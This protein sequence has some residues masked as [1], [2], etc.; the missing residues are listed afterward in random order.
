VLLVLGIGLA[1]WAGIAN[2]RQRQD[3]YVV[4]TMVGMVTGFLL[5][6]WCL[7]FSR[8]RWKVRLWICGAV[9]ALV[10]L[11]PVCFRL[12]GVSGDLV[13]IPEWRWKHPAPTPRVAASPSPAPAALEDETALG[14]YP[15]FLGPARNATVPGPRLARDW[16]AQPP[17]EIWQHPVG[18]GWSGFAV[19][20]HRAITQEQQGAEETVTC[21]DVRSGVLLWRHGYPAHFQSDLAGEGPR[22]TPT[23]A[24]NRVWTLGSTGILTCLRLDDGSL[25][26]SKDTLRENESKVNEWGDSCSPLVLGD[27]VVVS[28][29]GNRSRSLVAYDAATGNFVWGAGDAGAGYSSPLETTLGGV[30]QIL[31]FNAQGVFGH[32]AADGKI[33]WSY[34]WPRGHPHVAMPVVLPGDRVLASSGY[35]TGSEVFHVVRDQTGQFATE[36]VWKSTRL[37]AKFTNVVQRDGFIYGLDDGILVCLDAATGNLR[38]KEGRYGHGQEILV[39][40]LLL[41]TAE[42]GEVVLIEPNPEALRE[43]GRFQALKGKTWNPP[44]LVGACLLVRN[45]RE[46]ACFRLPVVK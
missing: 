38:W 26:W 43:L 27:W 5:W 46:A 30:P 6:V 10:A 20:G 24:S 39:G 17:Q 8:L 37:K 9:V 41:V 32:A 18:A 15:Q 13:P 22:A 44:A 2:Q 28:I 4:V 23:I 35:G 29:G 16:N 34:P 3:Q 11:T 31:S 45:D 14:D 12:H 33:L 7:C 1:I 42:S 19:A 36:R 21:Y 40:D 25:V